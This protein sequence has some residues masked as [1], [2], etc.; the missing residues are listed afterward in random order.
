MMEPLI[1]ALVM[2]KMDD[3]TLVSGLAMMKMDVG[4][5]NGGIDED[6]MM[7]TVAAGNDEDGRGY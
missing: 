3:G 4:Y 6:K 2:M 5:G 7:K 1:L